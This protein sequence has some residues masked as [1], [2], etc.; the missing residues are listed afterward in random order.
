MICWTSLT[1]ASVN[2]AASIRCCGSLARGRTLGCAGSV[3]AEEPE[4]LGRV[5]DGVV[6]PAVVHEDVH[7]AS[8][9]GQLGQLRHPLVELPFLVPVAEALGGA[10]DAGLPR[11]GVAPVEADDGELRRRRHDGWHRRLE[12]L[13]L[14]DAHERQ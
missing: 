13:W 10:R 12:A 1:P 6:A 7:L 4:Q 14:V 5:D 8:R 2:A 11:L 9:A 3:L